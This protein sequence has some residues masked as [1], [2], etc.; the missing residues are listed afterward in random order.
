MGLLVLV[1]STLLRR[2]MTVNAVK[3]FA[4]AV[5]LFLLPGFVSPIRAQM[6]I[7]TWLQ[8]SGPNAGNI[9]MTVEACCNGGY[10]LTYRFNGHSEMTMVVDSALDGADAPVLVAGKP[11]GETMRSSASTITT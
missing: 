2:R 4:S 10:R 6:G 11:S 3:R 7:G 8:Q 9:T 5:V 1:Q